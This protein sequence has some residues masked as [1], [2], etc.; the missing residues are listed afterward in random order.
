MNDNNVQTIEVND[1]DEILGTKA[2]TV[3]TADDNEPAAKTVFSQPS[4][5]SLSFLDNELSDDNLDD[6]DEDKSLDDSKQVQ[7]SDSLSDILDGDLDSDDDEDKLNKKPTGRPSLQKDAFVEAVTQLIDKG[8]LQPFDDEKPLSDYSLSEMQELIEANIAEKV[9][10]TAKEAPLQVFGSLPEEVQAVVSYALNGGTDIKQ[11]YK[12]LSQT[13][14][15]LELNIDNEVDQEKIVREWLT[16]TGFGTIEE[17]EDEILE[18]KDRGTLKNKAEKFKPKLDEKQSE[19]LKARLQEQE[20]RQERAREAAAKYAKTMYETLNQPELNGIKLTNQVQNMLYYGITDKTAYRDRS[21]NPTNELGHLLEEYQFGEK[22]NPSLI[23]E[24]LWLL[25]DPEGYKNNL[26]TLGKTDAAKSTYR[27]LK[28]EAASKTA[29]SSVSE[30]KDTPARKAEAG[31]SR[32]KQ[33]RS[34]FSR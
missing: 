17:V 16:A 22:S 4:G 34:I 28:T 9:N 8:V 18:L 27:S 33:Q 1:L 5:D 19:I 7:T 24:A 6:E 29:S 11:L 3:I 25:K 14:E 13:Q 12:Q 31:I 32:P 10:S 2:S 23:L 26:K 21:G 15:V 30:R 20:E